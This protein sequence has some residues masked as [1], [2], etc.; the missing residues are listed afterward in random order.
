MAIEIQEKFEIEAPAEQVWAFVSTPNQ[1]V[2]CLPGAS[3]TEALGWDS[4][5]SVE[6]ST[7]TVTIP[8]RSCA[9]FVP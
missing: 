5:V 2:G 7:A 1:V 3:L 8:G 6:G 4:T 9:V